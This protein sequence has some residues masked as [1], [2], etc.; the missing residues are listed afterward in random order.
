MHVI[1]LHILGYL[2]NLF[3]QFVKVTIIGFHVLS[4]ARDLV[5][6]T[7]VAIAP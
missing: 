1:L 2:L 6:G 5:G 3:E 4:R 7:I